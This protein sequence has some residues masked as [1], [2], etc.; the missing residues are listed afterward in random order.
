MNKKKKSLSADLS[1]SLKDEIIETAEL[2]LD[3]SLKDGIIKD[4]PIIKHIVNVYNIIDN[5]HGRYYI[6]KLKIFSL[7]L[8]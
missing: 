4:I 2:V 6:N 8:R 5:L 7:F 1:D 3:S